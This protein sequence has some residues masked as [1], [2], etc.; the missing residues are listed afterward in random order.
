MRLTR[1]TRPAQVALYLLAFGLA[2]LGV[3]LSLSQLVEPAARPSAI[4]ARNH[5][6][7]IAQSSRASGLAGHDRARDFILEE[8]TRLGLEPQ[9]QRTSVV[10][11]FEDSG[12][13]LGSVVENVWVRIPGTAPTG[14]I[15]ID[16]HYDSGA[17][18]PGAADCGTCVAA[19]LEVAR[20]VAT[21]PRLRNDIIVLFADA[22]EMGDLGARAWADAY[23][24]PLN[25]RVAI[26]LEG[27]GTTGPSEIGRA[28]V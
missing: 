10:N 24:R 12:D 19:A 25:V 11:R 21:G 9:L 2:G 27:M 22:E 1:A 3:N 18:G 6:A 7:A 20:T 4:T 15:V 17:T 8:L 14:A 23:A 5:V 13:F 16:A 26:A 28:H